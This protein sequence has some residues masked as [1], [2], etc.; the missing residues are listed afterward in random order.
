MESIQKGAWNNMINNVV[1]FHTGYV[2]VHQKG[3]WA[4]QT[5][6]LAFPY[7]GIPVKSPGVLRTL[8][9]LESF[10]LGSTGS[11]T[12][13]IMATGIDPQAEDQMTGI[14]SRI[15]KGAF[16][17][18]NDRSVLLGSGI[19]ENLKLDVGDTLLMISQ[20]YHG[21]NAAGKYPVKGIIHYPS[22][23][24]IIKHIS[25]NPCCSNRNTQRNCLIKIEI[26][27]RATIDFST[28]LF[29]LINH[30]H[31]SLFRCPCDATTWEN[32]LKHI[33]H[34]DFFFEFTFNH[35]D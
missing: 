17:E 13:G 31:T 33:G 11:N 35:G 25:I 27:N 15:T 9:R 20:G 21:V 28:I 3:Y 26:T 14:K 19:A 4:E 30:R 18:A 24:R 29:N 32:R 10:A 34:T 22:P 16:L 12:M 1:N 23:C 7:S 5:L 6:D 2:Q 8:P